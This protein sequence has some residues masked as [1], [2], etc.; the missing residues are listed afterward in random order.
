[1]CWQPRRRAIDAIHTA[2]MQF[3]S[4]TTAALSLLALLALAA[5]K[6]CPAA[7]ANLKSL[8]KG[9]GRVSVTFRSQIDEELQVYWMTRDGEE[10]DVG[11]LEPLGEVMHQSFEGHAFRVR[12]MLGEKEV[13]AETLLGRSTRQ[14]VLIEACGAALA[15]QSEAP[16]SPRA[17]MSTRCLVVLPNR[18]SATTSF[19]PSILRTRKAW[20]SKDW[21]ITSPSG[22]RIPTSCCSPSRVIQ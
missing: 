16:L 7:D 6:P 17:S 13:V 20:P 9:D 11:V 18:V 21:C 5:A 2:T 10:H 14:R 8:N 1:M 4:K 3:S 19:S 15:A 12:R 22:S